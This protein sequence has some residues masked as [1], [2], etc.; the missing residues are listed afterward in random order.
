MPLIDADPHSDRM[1]GAAIEVHQT[2]G[3]GL[4]EFIY[5]AALCREL[6]GGRRRTIHDVRL[7]QRENSSMA[8][9]RLP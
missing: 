5:D 3:R 8:G 1:I 2:I 4:L 7:L 6:D 9:L